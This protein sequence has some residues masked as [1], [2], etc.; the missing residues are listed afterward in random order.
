MYRLGVYV[1]AD[2]VCVCVEYTRLSKA[3]VDAPRSFAVQTWP[4]GLPLDTMFV[5]QSVTV[6]VA[7][8]ISESLHQGG[9]IDV[10]V[11][12]YTHTHPH[13]TLRC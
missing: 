11:R 9:W 12:T 3:G 5:G 8:E 2:G 10:T 1:C 6:R 4:D 7:A 13:S